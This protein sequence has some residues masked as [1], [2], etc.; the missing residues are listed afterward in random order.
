[1]IGLVCVWCGGGRPAVRVPTHLL[2]IARPKHAQ[3]AE[4]DVERRG[5]E[6]AV[7]LSDAH[8]VHGASQV[9][10]VDVVV[11]VLAGGHETRT[12]APNLPQ[13]V[14]HLPTCAAVVRA[15]RVLAACR[16]HHAHVVYYLLTQ[17]VYTMQS[18]D[19]F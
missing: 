11:E 10:G 15:S 16:L 1:M 9:G 2:Q 17:R 7:L 4:P 13:V 5:L 6:A 8:D 12:C 18:E 19:R 3:F 14:A